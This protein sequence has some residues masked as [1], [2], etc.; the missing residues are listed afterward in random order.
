MRVQAAVPERFWSQL[1]T[2]SRVHNSQLAAGLSQFPR[3]VGSRQC[4]FPSSQAAPSSKGKEV[5][6]TEI[7]PAN[8]QAVQFHRDPE[9]YVDLRVPSA[10][11]SVPWLRVRLSVYRVMHKGE[12]LIDAFS[13]TIDEKGNILK[14]K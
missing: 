2:W 13:F 8:P 4:Q 9:G 1:G 10:A 14:A 3:Q 5:C 11:P 12:K 6:F 7:F